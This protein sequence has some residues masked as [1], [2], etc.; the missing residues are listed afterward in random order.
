MQADADN[1]VV[2]LSGDAHVGGIFVRVGL[3]LIAKQHG[4]TPAH[5]IVVMRKTLSSSAHMCTAAM[6][7]CAL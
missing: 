5:C 3:G 6:C 1:Q 7:L 4:N 2:S